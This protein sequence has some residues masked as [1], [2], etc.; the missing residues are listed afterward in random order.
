MVIKIKMKK[1]FPQKKLIAFTIV[2]G[3]LFVAGFLVFDAKKNNGEFFKFLGG[4][5]DYRFAFSS[6]A[7]YRNVLEGNNSTDR[8]IQNY[9]S[10]IAIKNPSGPAEGTLALPS[11]EIFD[12]LLSKEVSAGISYEAVLE[13]DIHIV[14][15]SK[16]NNDLY[17][18]SV[19]GA[20]AM[21]RTD[22]WR[23]LLEFSESGSSKSLIAYA[24]ESMAVE[25]KLLNSSVPSSWKG[26]HMDLIN[27]ERKR[28]EVVR[29]IARSEDDPVKGLTAMQELFTLN[30]TELKLAETFAEKTKG[31]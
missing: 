10:Q 29:A 1:Q 2:V 27:F 17:L 30:E 15:D 13:K 25:K 6:D 20:M 21:H 4:G 26:F 28:T 7:E 31:I 19:K 16:E 22:L 3:A 18:S 12:Q 8:F 5:E 11:Q 24:S 23:S 14:S 9:G